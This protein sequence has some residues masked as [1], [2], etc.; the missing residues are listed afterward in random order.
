M[1][2]TVRDQPCGYKT[3]I[4]VKK[5]D[6]KVKVEIESECPDVNRFGEEL[7]LLDA[8]SILTKIPDNVVYRMAN[9][10]HS[11]CI[12]PWM[13]LKAA[14]IELGL[15]VKKFFTFQIEDRD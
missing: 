4:V 8:K 6:G 1:K 2:V 3:V 12:I 5:Q 11:T 13:V 7:P 14:E 10:R 9:I 15:N